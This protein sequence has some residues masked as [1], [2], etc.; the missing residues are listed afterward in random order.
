MCF[1]RRCIL[2]R[3]CI[4][5]LLFQRGR[6]TMNSTDCGIPR[7]HTDG[8]N[9]AKPNSHER[10]Q[11]ES[12][13]RSSTAIID[14]SCG[15]L[16]QLRCN[17]IHRTYMV[18]RSNEHVTST[19][20]KSFVSQQG[21]TSIALKK[22]GSIWKKTHRPSYGLGLGIET[23]QPSALPLELMPTPTTTRPLSDMP[24]ARDSFQTALL[25]WFG[26]ASS[27]SRRIP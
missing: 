23:I 27:S 25:S 14:C 3:A 20:E 16:T 13:S 1:R 15:E 12:L 9:G 8:H 6:N 4:P 24:V 19:W 22:M 10:Q 26:F 5:V 2:G 18:H 7:S 21:R 17:A 11:N